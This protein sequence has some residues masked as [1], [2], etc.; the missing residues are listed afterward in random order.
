MKNS[1][2]V[3]WILHAHSSLLPYISSVQSFS[4][5]RLFATPCIAAH[6]ASLSITNSL[7]SLRLASIESVILSSHLNLCRPLLL[8][9]T[10]PPSI[11]VFSTES[12]IRRSCN[13]LW[14]CLVAE[15]CPALLPPARLLCPWDFPGKNTGVNCNFLL[16]GIFLT[17]ESNQGLLHCRQILC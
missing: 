15:M 12:H 6:Q 8:M 13:C 11:K 7:S 16:Q 4:H 9:P 17:Q 14:C 3:V 1:E 5:V 2:S 10:I